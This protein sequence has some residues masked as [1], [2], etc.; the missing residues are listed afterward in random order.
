MTEPNKQW[1]EN[2]AGAI[3]TYW[4]R[5]GAIGMMESKYII[6]DYAQP[7]M[8]ELAEAKE[9]IKTLTLESTSETCRR[10][11]LQNCHV[12]EDMRC[13]DNTSP[14]K[15][16]IKQLRFSRIQNLAEIVALR[17]DLEETDE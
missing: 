6:L 2:C 17:H 16:E 13:G 5:F 7:V 10:V 11:H 14:M 3:Y 1:I 12:C 8:D 4:K 9:E 15:K